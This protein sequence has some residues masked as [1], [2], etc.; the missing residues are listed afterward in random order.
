MGGNANVFLCRFRLREEAAGKKDMPF[1]E[2]D[3]P[4]GTAA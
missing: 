2:R 4:K 1:G 3:Q